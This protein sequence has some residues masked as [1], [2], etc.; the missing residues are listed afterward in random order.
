MEALNQYLNAVERR[1]IANQAEL[2]K[3]DGGVGNTIS[4]EK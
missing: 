1:L 3:I 4:A 2:E